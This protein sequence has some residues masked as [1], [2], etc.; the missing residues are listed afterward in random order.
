[1]VL[2]L[3]AVVWASGCVFGRSFQNSSADHNNGRLHMFQTPGELETVADAVVSIMESSGATLVKRRETSVGTV[4]LS[5]RVSVERVS[6]S[7][8]E[9][10]GLYTQP[11][12]WFRAGTFNTQSITQTDYI[13]YGALFYV[14]LV[15]LEQLVELRALGLPVIDGMTACPTLVAR[16][17]TCRPVPSGSPQSVAEVVS[18]RTGISVTGAKEAEV[19]TGLFGQLKRKRWQDAFKGSVRPPAREN[20]ESPDSAFERSADE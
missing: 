20:T 14:E 10:T 19:I 17:R 11:S 1:M 3:T 7:R 18:K 6:G 4:V 12:R 15:P 2:S 8:S 9:S 13:A 5:F 16:Y